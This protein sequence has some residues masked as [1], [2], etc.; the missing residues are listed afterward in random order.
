MFDRA[1]QSPPFGGRY[2]VR[3]EFDVQP[4]LLKSDI[5]ASR[6]TERATYV[7]I[8]GRDAAHCVKWQAMVRRAR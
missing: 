8:A 7:D 5:H 1:Q 2:A 6:D 3:S 4:H